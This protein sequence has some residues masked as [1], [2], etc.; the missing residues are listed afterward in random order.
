MKKE[1]ESMLRFSKITIIIVCFTLIITPGAA[2]AGWFTDIYI[3]NSSTGD[4]TLEVEAP[5]FSQEQ[6]VSFDSAAIFGARVGYWFDQA[7]FVGIA[8]D[9]SGVNREVESLDFSGTFLS[10]LLMFR[11]KIK[12]SE[13]YPHGQF[14][15]YI[16][17]GPSVVFSQFDAKAEDLFAGSPNSLQNSEDNFSAQSSDLGF[18]GR[19]GFRYHFAW[20]FSLFGEYRL[21]Y[22]KAGYNDMISGFSIDVD[23]KLQTHHFLVGVGWGF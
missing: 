19:L 23:A 6:D 21:T 16:A 17:F 18:D 15:P 1:M 10:P 11:F 22:V 5:F 2:Q 4:A 14:Q 12:P 13:I 8:A 20:N 9:L 7:P 3:G